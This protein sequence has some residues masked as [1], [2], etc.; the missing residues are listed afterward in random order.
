M[1][2]RC[3]QELSYHTFLAM[4]KPDVSNAHDSITVAFS[5]YPHIAYL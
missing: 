1:R 3:L 5:K 4:T 2:A